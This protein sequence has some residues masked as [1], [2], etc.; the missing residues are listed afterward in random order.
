[1]ESPARL[2][3]VPGSASCAQ[4]AEVEYARW[5]A[6]YSIRLVPTGGTHFLSGVTT[7]HLLSKD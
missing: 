5:Q 3:R 6:T 7:G 2:P 1:M 4:V